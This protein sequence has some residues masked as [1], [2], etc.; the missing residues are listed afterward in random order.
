M[1]SPRPR[2][3]QLQTITCWLIAVHLHSIAPHRGHPLLG[4]CARGLC[5][6]LCSQLQGSSYTPWAALPNRSVLLCTQ[7]NLNPHIH[8][9]GY[10]VLLV[11]YEIKRLAHRSEMSQRPVPILTT[12]EPVPCNDP[13]AHICD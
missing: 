13:N 9:P 7:N 8:D 12:G 3:F 10:F 2:P 4:L 6:P 1:L 11:S 5:A